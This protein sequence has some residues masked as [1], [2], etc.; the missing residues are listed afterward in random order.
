MKR[1]KKNRQ[2]SHDPKRQLFLAGALHG[3]FSTLAGVLPDVTDDQ[4]RDL[5]TG[6]LCCIKDAGIH[7][8]FVLTALDE[9]VNHNPARHLPEMARILSRVRVVAPFSVL[10]APNN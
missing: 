1:K 8:G 6:W 10:T 7:E 2:P 9:A 5:M 4:L 3:M